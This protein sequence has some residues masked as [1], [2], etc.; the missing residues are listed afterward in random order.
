[1]VRPEEDIST[2]HRYL[3]AAERELQR[4]ALITSQTLRFHRQS[5]NAAPTFCDEMMGEAI[6]IYHGRMLNSK[7]EVETR[8]RS[9]SAVH[10]FAGEIRQVLNNLVGNGID[11]MQTKG[12]RLL[13]RSRDATEWKTGRSGIVL[14]VADTGPGMSPE[15]Q[16]KIFEPFFTTKAIGATGLGLWVSREIVERH[17]GSLIFRSSQRPA[18]SGTVFC[19]FLP[20]EPK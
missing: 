16:K 6:A 15:S 12:G 3:V 8:K 2:V 14:T 1:M 5:T 17:R 18:R 11:A 13:I 4:V 19:L 9:A 7:I 20:L 10:C